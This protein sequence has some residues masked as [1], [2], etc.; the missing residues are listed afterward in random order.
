MSAINLFNIIP[1]F[2][3]YTMFVI[4]T[5]EELFVGFETICSTLTG[6]FS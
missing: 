6:T 2:S 4:F 3:T 1:K 5:D